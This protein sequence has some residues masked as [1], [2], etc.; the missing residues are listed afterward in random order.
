MSFRID[1]LAVLNLATVGNSITA[2]SFVKSGGT[3]S[4]FLKADGSVDSSAY[5]TGITS[6]M[7]TTALGYTP[8]PNTRTLTI[9]GTAYDLSAD[10]SWTI[11][12]GVSSV[13]ASGSGISASPTTGAVIISNT[14]VTSNV[15]GTGISVSGATGAVTIT[16]TGVTSVAAGTG[17]SVSASTGGVTIT[18]AGVT[19]VNGNTGA[20][21]GIITT[22]NYNS[23][24][25]TLTGGGA[26]GTWGI[27][28]SGNSATTSQTNFTSL[29]VNSNTVL[30]AGNYSTYAAPAANFKVL[31]QNVSYDVTRAIKTSGGG[32][33]I[34]SGYSSGSNRPTTYDVSAQFAATND[35]AFEIAADWLSTAG[36]TLFARSL[37]DCCQNWSSWIT[38]LTSLNYNSYSPTLT[39]GGASGTWSINI[40]GNSATTLQTNFTTLTL[41]SATVATQSW[42]SSQGYVTGGPYLPLSGGTMSGNLTLSGYA[43]PHITL[44]TSG[45]SYSYLELYDGSTYG[46]IIKN[47]S[48]STSNGVLAG[49][50]YLYTDNNKPTQI[51][52]SG[53]S[54]AAFLSN[55]TVYIRGQVYVGGDGASTGTQLVYNS[56]TW[57]ITA[58]GN[59]PYGNWVGTTG[60]ND[61]KLY[62]RTNGD[63][64]HYLWN[65]GD[66]WEELNAYEGTGFRITSVG[67]SVGVLYVYGSSNGGY[68]YSPYSFR[69]PIFYDSDNT[70]YY[71]NFAD[72][73]TSI[74]IAGSVNA[75]TYNKPGLLLNASGSS[76]SGAAFGMQQI[77]SEGWT[78]IFV[79][80]EPYTGWG[81]YH[82]NPNN[83]FIVTSENSTGN[84]GSHTVPSRSSGNR[85]A[86]VKHRFD[87]NNGEFY[88]GGLIY[89]YASVRAPIFYDSE[90]T[91]Y[92]ADFHS[93]SNSGIRLRGGMLMGPNPTWGAYLQVGGD[94]NTNSSAASVVATNGNLHLDSANGYATYINHYYGNRIY[95]GSGGAAGGTYNHSSFSPSGFLYVGGNGTDASYRLQVNGTGYA[96]SDFRAPIFYDSDNTGYYGDFASTSRLNVLEANSIY[97]YGGLSTNGGNSLLGVQS[98]GGASRANGG[99]TET[100]AFKITLPSGIPVYGMFKLVIHIY[101]YG[102]RGN[103]YEIHCGG[104]MYPNYMYNR[105]QVQYGSSNSPLNVRYGNDGTNGC[106]WI[107]DTNTTWSYPQIWVSEFMM[108]YSNTSWTTW[109]SGWNISLVTSYGNSG[110]MDGPYTCE[111]GYAASAGSASTSSQV[112]INYNNDSNSTYQLLWGSGNS[113]YGTSGVYV[114]PYDDR[115]YANYFS[116][117]YH[118]DVYTSAGSDYLRITDNQVYRPGAGPLYLNWSSNGNVYATGPGGGN[119]G[120]GNNSPSYKLHVSGDIYANGG[121]LRVSGT[122]GLYFESYGGGWHMTDSTWIRSYNSKNVYMSADVRT[123]GQYQ[124]ESGY[125]YWSRYGTYSGALHRIAYISFDWDGNYNSYS[126][127]G[128]SSTGASGGFEDSVSIN[129]F[130][131]ITL[132]LDSN[133]NNANSYLRIS[134][135]TTGDGTFAWIGRESG[136]ASMYLQR[137]GVSGVTSAPSGTA[138][139]IDSGGNNYITFRNTADNGTYS[140]LAFVDNNIGGFVVFGNYGAGVSDYMAIAGYNG[141][142]LQYGTA[143][144][145]DPTARVTVAT[146]NGSGFNINN[147]ALTQQ[148]NQVLHAGN[149]NS[150]A[151]TL[152]GGGASGTWSINITGSAGSATSAS[153]ATYLTSSNYINRSG[154]SGNYN[155]DFSNTPAGSVR[156]QG[157]DAYVSNS[158]GGAWWFVDNYR[159][160]N[161]SNIWGT[162]IAWGWEDNANR[163]AQR[164]VTGGSWSGWVYY[165]N[166]A[167]YTSYAIARGGDTVDGV[168]YFRTNLGGYSGSLSNARM[169]AYSDS[170][171]SAFISFHKGGYYAV[172][173]GL[174]ADNWFRIGGWSAASNR[175][176]MD[177]SGNLYMAGDVTAYS[178]ARVKENIVTVDDALNKVLNLRGVYYNRTDSDDKRRKVGVIAQEIMEVIP[179]VVGQDNDGMYNVSYGNIVGV[180]IEAIKE[181]TSI[182]DDLKQRI[183]QL[184]S[185]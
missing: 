99:S 81:L 143:N 111:F 121:W 92:Y 137:S 79:D 140:G 8:V 172:N 42:V 178:D 19:S 1:Q 151:P 168:I 86:Y 93:T 94:G 184:E 185:K 55:G 91:N 149:Y 82:D 72:T 83:Y 15:A 113:V 74:N 119:M 148:G 159:H 117:A 153:Y 96:T 106:I 166:S 38:L 176:Q 68:T 144:S 33:A 66:D 14:G 120:V 101:E 181:Q 61:N 114:N 115:V 16:N 98:P 73:G 154:T 100:G 32:L 5:I 155:T 51:V 127:H 70:T 152:T 145:V 177:M 63:N 132:R 122:S 48:S 71:A 169:Q 118:M 102:Q 10:R 53:S 85:T 58:T 164:N 147:G 158:P 105:F 7:I 139:T 57:S 134:D 4:Q 52:H 90:D 87:Q 124:L 44:T 128:I 80:F 104:H 22:S 95:F 170:N 89:S 3:S 163:L 54:N 165:L 130:N 31:G 160:S 6:G 17:I 37:R 26:S 43:N 39:G 41:N 65:A 97:T 116:A 28:I 21:T 133:G 60:M 59:L 179:E 135:N 23:Y 30:H 77:T 109:R 150:Y 167:N 75:A 84:F 173:M 20:V 103:G 27:S 112:S 50:L 110:A 67:G 161:G 88:A 123:G 12:A 56:G 13:T 141:G 62:L 182:I 162:Q 76:S 64:N 157:D 46:Y 24:S 40:T 35:I 69:A 180:L 131:D 107:G 174:D 126:N 34:Y 18:N 78:G 49:A 36:P 175:L 29:T 138:I 183:S 108:G 129:S 156:H 11:A 9:N 47:V 146:W 136:V 45:G 2:G 125:S 171:N 25:P 142:V